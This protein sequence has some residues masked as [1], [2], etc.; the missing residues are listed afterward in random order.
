MIAR[1]P[2]RIAEPA[3]SRDLPGGAGLSCGIAD[4]RR[5]RRPTFYAL[6]TAADAA[7]Y[8]AKRAGGGHVRMSG[9][10]LDP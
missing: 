10:P 3:C 5:L 4:T 7:Q 6:Y 2:P 9:E 8:S 1:K